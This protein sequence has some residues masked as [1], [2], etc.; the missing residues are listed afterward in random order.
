MRKPNDVVQLK[1]RFSERLRARLEKAAAKTDDSL[2]TEIIRRLERSFAEEDV[3]AEALG[4]HELRH[5][6]LSVASSFADGCKSTARASGH[7]EWVA[8][9]WMQDQDCY[10]IGIVR[11]MMNLIEA[12]PNPSPREK[13][14]VL[15]YLKTRMMNSLIQS[16]DLKVDFHDGRGPHGNEFVGPSDEE[17]AAEGDVA[18]SEP[19]PITEGEYDRLVVEM[20]ENSRRT[21]DEAQKR[22]R[23]ADAAAEAA[24]KAVV[25]AVVRG[26]RAGTGKWP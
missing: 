25:K 6:A 18:V 1:L 15:V 19:H 4:G 24:V 16:G 10:R 8:R 26:R 2:N 17:R 14:L 23:T 9:D 21:A 3:I 22:A 7:D 11:A 20:E 13:E 12:M 5:L